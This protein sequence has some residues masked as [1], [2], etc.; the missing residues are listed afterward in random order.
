[1]P[2]FPYWFHC[3]YLCLC[4]SVCVHIHTHSHTGTRLSTHRHTHTYAHTNAWTQ[5]Q[6]SFWMWR[7]LPRPTE[8]LQVTAVTPRPVIVLPSSTPRFTSSLAAPLL[9]SLEEVFCCYCL[10]SLVCLFLILTLSPI[11]PKSAALLPSM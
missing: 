1:M 9:I 6:Q 5:R 8:E 4:V 10:F 2:L 3:I 11:H 7:V